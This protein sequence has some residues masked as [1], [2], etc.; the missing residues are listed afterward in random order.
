MDYNA[1]VVDD[2]AVQAE[3]D[4]LREHQAVLEPVERPAQMGDVVT[5][6]AKGFL[7]EGENPSDFLLADQDVALVL[8]EKADWPMPGFAAQVI[9]ISAG[10]ERKFDLAFADDYVNES[11]RS[12]TAHF[13]VK[14]KDE[15]LDLQEKIP[16]RQHSGRGEEIAPQEV[17][18]EAG[19]IT[20]HDRRRHL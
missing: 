9:G 19:S 8:E 1:P 16:A 12:Q 4:H 7:N 5:L 10:E 2:A 20:A 15:W 14:A 11:L 13:E 6:D 18:L 3:M 17:S